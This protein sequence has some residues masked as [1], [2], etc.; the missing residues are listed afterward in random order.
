MRNC[1]A[2]NTARI[3]AELADPQPMSRSPV[4]H[5]TPT[6]GVDVP[7]HDP[8]AARGRDGEH[9]LRQPVPFRSRCLARI[10]RPQSW[11]EE[12]DQDDGF[13]IGEVNESILCH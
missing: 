3:A 13:E 9:Q 5:E 11:S 7:L 12:R 6:A 8:G 1:E 2:A 4:G 10:R